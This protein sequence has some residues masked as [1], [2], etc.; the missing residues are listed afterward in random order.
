[1]LNR[2]T[3]RQQ[4]L[5][6]MERN[7]PHLILE[8]TDGAWLDYCKEMMFILD[9]D[10]Q[11][12]PFIPKQ[13][14][15]AILEQY[16]QH[17]RDNKQL[18]LIC[19]KP[20]QVGY[21]TLFTVL[22]M[23]EML[24]RPNIEVLITSNLK[25]GASTNIFKKYEFLMMNRPQNRHKK[26]KD[27]FMTGSVH[28]QGR[29]ILKN[30]S[31][32][33][34]CG[35]RSDVGSTLT[36]LHISEAAHF[37]DLAGIMEDTVQSLQDSPSKM[38]TIEST[39]DSYQDDFHSKWNEAE[40][41][42][43]NWTQIFSGWQDEETYTKRIP[44]GER[45]EFLKSIGKTP[46]YGDEVQL[47]KDYD[48]TPEQLYWRRWC[49][50]NQCDNSLAKFQRSYPSNPRECFLSADQPLFHIPSLEY[51]LEHTKK[52]IALGHMQ[53]EEREVSYDGTELAEF[54]ESRQGATEIWEEPDPYAE[55]IWTCDTAQGLKSGDFS[56]GLLAK[57]S[58]FS[59]VA[60]I[61]GDDFTKPKIVDF[62]K[63]LYYL[64]RWY[65]DAKG[66]HE[67][68]NHGNSITSLF[69]A[70]GASHR[71]MFE[72]DVIQSN[73]KELGFYTTADK[74]A[75]AMDKLIDAM[76]IEDGIR[77]STLSPTIPDKMI[78]DEMIHMITDGRQI[79]ARRKGDHRIP[80][81]NS[82]GY[83]DDCVIA[84]MLLV[85]VQE[86]LP[87]PKTREEMMVR[88]HG[89]SHPL[90]AHLGHITIHNPFESLDAI[91]PEERMSDMSF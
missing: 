22:N 19:L 29:F 50:K 71:L 43:S 23:V 75:T 17:K 4:E 27:V 32:L 16:W 7:E 70:W 88:A 83:H 30:G 41:P 90:T 60:K 47:Q 54:V 51:H 53:P 18:R 73:S 12:V 86:A 68:N 48:L 56:V 21:S 33:R 77:I 15:M 24:C 26:P 49:I 63:Q 3:K 58:P 59:V 35:E 87:T 82:M 36:N 69:D 66:L 38:L 89:H 42:N 31:Y 78:I 76:M 40:D 52:P 79:R 74:K 1:M 10:K 81:S 44:K 62:S 57:R 20:R 46:D 11:R 5:I 84:M 45:D 64:T 72:S 2:L 37:H 85:L 67:S 80:G 6:I 8:N 91:V 55:Y 25:E 28:S 14:Q 9:A 34:V 39:A 13:S 61:R 65:N